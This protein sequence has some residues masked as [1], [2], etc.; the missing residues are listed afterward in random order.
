MAEISM[1][2]PACCARLNG[3]RAVQ[4]SA[5]APGTFFTWLRE[6]HRSWYNAGHRRERRR[7]EE[8]ARRFGGKVTW[9]EMQ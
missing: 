5:R 8:D 4:T 6:L 1:P 2:Q 9:D 7:I 3:A